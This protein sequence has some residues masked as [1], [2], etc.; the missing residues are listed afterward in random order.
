[1]MLRNNGRYQILKFNAGSVMRHVARSICRRF[2]GDQRGNIGILFGLMALPMLAF[3]G[4]A[5]DHSRAKHARSEL[6]DITDA[7]AIAG[8]RLPATANAN[9]FEAAEK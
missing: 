9:R 4:L 3:A 1:M 8:A 5:I 6:Q 7:A 2:L